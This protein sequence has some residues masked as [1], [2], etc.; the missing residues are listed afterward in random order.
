MGLFSWILPG[1]QITSC[2]VLVNGIVPRHFYEGVRVMALFVF[3]QVPAWEKD[4]TTTRIF[5]DKP[6]TEVVNSTYHEKEP[7]SG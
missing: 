6:I 4:A 2:A 3:Y 5:F 1:V 7:M